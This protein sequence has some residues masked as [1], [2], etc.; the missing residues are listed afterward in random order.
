M[1]PCAAGDT[2]K[3]RDTR[4][5]TIGT[6]DQPGPNVQRRMVTVL[7]C[8]GARAVIVDAQVAG[9][10]PRQVL[11]LGHPRG[12]LA[13]E[14]VERP[15]SDPPSVRHLIGLHPPAEWGPQLSTR[16]RD[17]A[18][19][20]HR[21][22][23]EALKD[24]G[25]RGEDGVRAGDLVGVGIRTPLDE[26][27]PRPAHREQAS[28]RAAGHASADDRYVVQLGGGPPELLRYWSLGLVWHFNL[29]VIRQRL[30]AT[31]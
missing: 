1:R 28:S 16:P 23:S 7:Q 29:R 31:V 13:Q 21:R 17:A 27:H 25:G 20:Q 11:D 14:R 2:R 10:P 12:H 22:D 4:A 30:F 18:C 19:V 6:D 26:C 9:R 8:D 15:S 3:A 24:R 5:A